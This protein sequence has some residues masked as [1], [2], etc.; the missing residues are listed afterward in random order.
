MW[1]RFA[2]VPVATR[3]LVAEPLEDGQTWMLAAVRASAFAAML[4]SRVSVSRR[5]TRTDQSS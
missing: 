4:T 5:P 2:P 3:L 1:S